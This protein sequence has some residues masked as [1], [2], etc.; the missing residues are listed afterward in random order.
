MTERGGAGGRRGKYAGA[1]G[2]VV[3]VVPQ[4]IRL[5]RRNGI[6]SN[7]KYKCGANR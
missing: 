6:F 4:E 5:S 1:E 3:V 2:C 7:N